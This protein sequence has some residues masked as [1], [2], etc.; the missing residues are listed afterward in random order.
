MFIIKKK[1]SYL[2]IKTILFYYFIQCSKIDKCIFTTY[3]NVFMNYNN[4][5][6]II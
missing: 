6:Y 1:F 3:K 5:N 2:F 4:L